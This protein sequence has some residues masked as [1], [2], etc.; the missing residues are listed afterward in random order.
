M[1]WL[2]LP[3]ILLTT[4]CKQISSS[5]ATGAQ[6]T[7]PP[8]SVAL[9]KG[10]TR[11]DS[12][13]PTPKPQNGPQN[14]AQPTPEPSAPPTPTPDSP[15]SPSA[16][17]TPVG[18]PVPIVDLKAF[19]AISRGLIPVKFIKSKHIN[20]EIFSAFIKFI[21]TKYNIEEDTTS[22]IELVIAS[23]KESASASDIDNYF[24]AEHKALL[25]NFPKT[26]GLVLILESDDKTLKTPREVDNYST[27]LVVYKVSPLPPFLFVE[28]IIAS[29]RLKYVIFQNILEHFGITDLELHKR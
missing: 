29:F 16:S 2:L 11:I 9:T 25:G 14:V 13:P 20:D 26:L 6:S 10:P 17:P 8:D 7:A 4:S 18:S 5:K 23:A 27:S 22:P 24:K 15:P 28:P 1:K 12:K 19:P 3:L 21:T